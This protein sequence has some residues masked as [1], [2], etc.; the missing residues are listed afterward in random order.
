MK[1]NNKSSLFFGITALGFCSFITQLVLM[2]EYLSV[3]SGNEF[4]IGIYLSGWM[5]LNGDGAYWARRSSQNTNAIPLIIRSFVFLAI[6]PFISLL[7]FYLVNSRFFP[8]GY[9]PGPL[10]IWLYML[11]LIA[12]F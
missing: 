5:M 2:R 9:S 3:F 4:I 12:P 6:I 7:A 1:V 11:I 8:P 10:S